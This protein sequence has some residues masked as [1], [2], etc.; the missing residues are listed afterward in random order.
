MWLLPSGIISR[1]THPLS[2]CLCGTKTLTEG[3]SPIIVRCTIKILNELPSI[4]LPK[5]EIPKLPQ[6][7]P[8]AVPPAGRRIFNW[9]TRPRPQ[10]PRFSHTPIVPHP[11]AHPHPSVS[12]LSTCDP[13]FADALPKVAT[14]EAQN[15]ACAV[16]MRGHRRFLLFR[17]ACGLQSTWMDGR[18]FY[19]LLRKCFSTVLEE[20]WS[21]FAVVRD[22]VRRW[23]ASGAVGRCKWSV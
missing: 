10:N 11:L 20:I 9:P 14:P 8:Q 4:P 2:D 23:K 3:S 12:A 21:V 5:P 18:S 16:G 22:G 7:R 17:Y 13:F 15:L 1:N 19:G 6:T